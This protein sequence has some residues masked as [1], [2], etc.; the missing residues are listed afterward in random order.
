MSSEI[1]M[2]NVEIAFQRRKVHLLFHKRYYG[3]NLSDVFTKI[4]E[5]YEGRMIIEKMI[6]TE[7]P[8]SSTI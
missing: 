8:S 3:K 5:E 4:I 2:Y 6:L 1:R 7:V